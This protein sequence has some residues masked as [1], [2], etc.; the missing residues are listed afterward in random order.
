MG[1]RI[2]IFTKVIVLLLVLLVPIVCLYGYSHKVSIKVIQEEIESSSVNKLSF[3]VSQVET[4]MDQLSSSSLLLIEDPDVRVFQTMY[5]DNKLLNLDTIT[6]MNRLKD[7]LS[8]V[9]SSSSWN[10]TMSVYSTSM[11]QVISTD[12][13]QTF[14]SDYIRKYTKPDW[15]VQTAKINGSTQYKFAW[16]TVE[17]VSPI[18]RTGKVKFMFEV[19]FSGENL[20]RLLDQYKEGGKGDPFFFNPRDG[21]ISNSSSDQDLIVQLTRKWREDQKLASGKQVMLLDGQRYLVSFVKSDKMGWYLIDYVPLQE[22][23][24]PIT[25]SKDLFIYSTILLL[26]LSVLATF[27]LYS[28]VQ[29]PI[30]SLMRGVQQLKKGNY[31]VRIRTRHGNEFGF[32]VERFNELAEQIQELIEKVYEEKIRSREAVLK[33]LQSQI[34]PH[35]LYNCL[36]YIHSMAKLNE[37]AAIS[38][39]V[40][41]LGKYYRYTTRLEKDEAGLEEEIQ[42][43]LNYLEIQKLRMPR[44]QY[45]LELPEGMKPLLVPRL[46]IQPL[47]ENAVIHGI[48]LNPAGGRIRISGTL[49]AHEYTL[50]V[51]DDGIELSQEQLLRLRNRLNRPLDDQMGCGVWNVH[52]RLLYRYGAP[53]GL[54]FDN[55]SLGGLKT[56]IRWNR[57]P[58]Q[59]IFRLEGVM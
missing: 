20:I 36:A 26:T 2:T 14:D 55:S 51:E 16:R 53:S 4:S 5:L 40:H 34:N 42:L 49:D 44:I 43:V 32:L 39:M 52:Q 7:K 47:I 38:A 23:L 59:E 12:A 35:F 19:K 56:T 21:V 37:N 10:N 50:V 9:S 46:L 17:P 41:H 18:P 22:I 28:Q 8:M 58:M 25:K 31:A 57:V 3:L 30:R 48:E 11:K 24:S 27:L 6:V 29:V 54:E 45:T 15:Q 1:S 13:G 33:Q